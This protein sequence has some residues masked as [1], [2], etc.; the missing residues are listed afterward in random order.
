MWEIRGTIQ[1][2]FWSIQSHLHATVSY[3]LA[4]YTNSRW[5]ASIMLSH[6]MVGIA[7]VPKKIG[8]PVGRPLS[9]SAKVGKRN[10]VS[11]GRSVR[12]SEASTATLPKILTFHINISPWLLVIIPH[13]FTVK[14][15]VYSLYVS[16]A[17]KL[18]MR[19][20]WAVLYG[21][22]VKQSDQGNIVQHILR[23]DTWQ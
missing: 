16:W 22:K 11:H 8:R 7:T 15:L 5:K 19:L 12:T 2:T 3:C 21:R 17:S 14:W 18:K 13:T 4:I 6:F 23:E 10:D 1:S 9:M 20:R